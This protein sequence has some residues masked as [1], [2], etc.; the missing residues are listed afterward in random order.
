MQSI[1]SQLIHRTLRASN[2]NQHWQLTGEKL[3]K[4]VHNKQK[5]DR[6]KPLKLINKQINIKMHYLDDQLYYLLS[7]KES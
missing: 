4:R 2:F 1:H 7:P 3:E 5:N 6:Q